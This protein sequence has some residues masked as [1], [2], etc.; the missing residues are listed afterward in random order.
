MKIKTEH[1][2]MFQQ[3]KKYK[4]EDRLKF[5]KT[6]LDKLPIKIGM[7][8]IFDYSGDEELKNVMKDYHERKDDLSLH[9]L[10]RLIKLCGKHKKHLI[11][12]TENFRKV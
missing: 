6:L 8:L 1:L 7:R 4:K 2:I 11:G 5:A 3:I 9:R 12:F 10:N